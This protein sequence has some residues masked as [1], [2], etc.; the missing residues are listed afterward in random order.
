LENTRDDQA[1]LDVD[2]LTYVGLPAGV[3]TEEWLRLLRVGTT[4]FAAQPYQHLAATH[5]RA[6]HDDQV[7]RI[8][9]AQRRDQLYRR[10]LTGRT[11]RA[12]AR[13]T[14]FTL[15]YGYQS[16]RSL[17][18]LLAVVAV[19]VVLG[20]TLGAH[21]GLAR[22]RPAAPAAT[23]C[24]MVE[25]IGVGLD[26]GRPLIKASTRTN[27][28]VTTS[29]TGQILTVGNWVLQLFAW[30]FAT[31]FVAGFTSAVRKI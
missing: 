18:G 19:A 24:S 30:A 27:C 7:R 17:L 11:E 25:R 21:G 3:S 20:I 8:L 23:Q 22:T 2:G 31:L 14:G 9:I 5:R 15:G 16:W 26:L 6:G 28:D 12:W 29:V 1:R 4:T 13:V 10:A